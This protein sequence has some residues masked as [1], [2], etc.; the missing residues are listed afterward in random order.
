[1][2]PQKRGLEQRSP[3]KESRPAGPRQTLPKRTGQSDATTESPDDASAWWRVKLRPLLERGNV[4]GFGSDVMQSVP[5][6]MVAR[7]G[8][9]R[10]GARDV[11]TSAPSVEQ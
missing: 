2:Q 6:N 10:G 3:A 4:R 11:P 8:E 1:M 5:E 9:C 7:E